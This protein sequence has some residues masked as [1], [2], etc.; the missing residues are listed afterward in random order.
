VCGLQCAY[1]DK[2]RG[3]LGLASKPKLMVSRFVPQNW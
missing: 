3:F 1:E 2:E